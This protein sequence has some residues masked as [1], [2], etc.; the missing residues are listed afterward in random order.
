[1]IKALEEDPNVFDYDGQYDKIQEQKRKS[2][3][4]LLKKDR[5]VSCHDFHAGL[6]SS[7]SVLYGEC[8]QSI[9]RN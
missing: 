3:P 1:M 5:D 9:Y 7:C 6:N 8:S 2:D 4:R